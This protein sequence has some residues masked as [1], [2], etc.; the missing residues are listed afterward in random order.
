[1]P[2]AHLHVAVVVPCVAAEPRVHQ[3]SIEPVHDRIPVLLRHVWAD[4]QELGVP[5]ILWTEQ[6]AFVPEQEGIRSPQAEVT[7]RKVPG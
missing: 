7:V 4:V 2:W 6:T 3:Y 1:M 5:H